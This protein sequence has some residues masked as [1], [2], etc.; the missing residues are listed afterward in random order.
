[1]KIELFTQDGCPPCEFLKNYLKEMNAS[2]IEYN[3][4]QD[5]GAKKRMMFELDSYSTP[6]LIIDDEVIR[7]V[8]M[9]QIEAALQ[10]R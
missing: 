4:S 10:K 8:Q 1:M 9:E 2:Y 3:V 7:G 5:E 6:T